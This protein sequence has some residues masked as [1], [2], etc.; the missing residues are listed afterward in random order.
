MTPAPTTSTG[1]A[2][3]RVRAKEKPPAKP[4]SRQKLTRRYPDDAVTDYAARVNTGD[5]LTNRLVGLA[6]ARHLR[7]LE[8]RREL[9]WDREAAELALAFWPEV[10]RLPDDGYEPPEGSADEDDGD[11]FEGRPFVLSPHQCFYVGSLYGWKRQSDG[12]LRF[13]VAYIE[14]SKGDG[15]T[16]TLSGILLRATC[17]EGVRGAQVFAAGAKKDQA[18][19]LLRDADAMRMASPELA[20]RL[21]PSGAFPNTWNLAH[22]ESRSFLKAISSENAQSGPRVYRAG[23]EELHEHRTPIVWDKL[24]AGLKGRPNAFIVGMTNSGFDRTSVCWREHEYSVKVLE[25]AIQDDTRF[26][27]ITGL[28][29]CT[30]CRAEGKEF[31]TEDCPKCDDWRDEKVW[32]KAAPNLGVTVTRDYYRQEV[33]EA[34][35]MPTKRNLVKRLLFCIW[36]EGQ[37][38]WIPFEE[39]AACKRPELCKLEL[40]RGRTAFAGIDLAGTSDLAALVLYFPAVDDDGEPSIVLP[41]FFLPKASIKERMAKDRVPYDLW[42]Q[43]GHI[44]ATDGNVTDYRAIRE[45]LLWLRGEQGI[46]IK[47][48]PFDPDDATQ[49][50]TDLTDD[51]FLAVPFY[52]TKRLYTPPVREMEAEITKRAVAHPGHPVMDWNFTNIIIERNREGQ[53][54]PVKGQDREKNDGATAMFMAKGR[55]M[56]H[57]AKKPGSVYETRGLLTL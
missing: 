33:R 15:K 54:K 4:R 13:V 3:P 2:K 41:F 31:P 57:T 25:G 10:L 9:L 48:V 40:L 56:L 19:L 55:A 24:K 6:A 21:K 20:H 28:D 42:V 32:P 16:P 29:A 53:V 30:K 12:L 5:I 26:A 52:Q 22:V 11:G 50:S 27:F 8:R 49:L 14:V 37:E 36:T 46:V 7:D 44:D 45:K 43:K 1:R 17:A 38:K 18:L 35:G 47:E 34:E 51:G 23:A 39:W